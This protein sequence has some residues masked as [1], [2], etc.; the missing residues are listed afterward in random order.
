MRC[1]LIAVGSR[2]DIQP[3]IALALGLKRAGWAVRFA[4]HADFAATALMHGLEFVRISGSSNQ[5]YNGPASIA[6][7]DHIRTGGRDLKRFFDSYLSVFYRRHLH[8]VEAACADADLI[9]CWPW[10]RLAPTL[11]QWRGVPV[12]V[13][14]VNPVIHLPTCTYPNPFQYPRRR[15]LGVVRNRLSWRAGEAIAGIGQ[16]ELDTWRV[17]RLGL[18]PLPWREDLKRLRRMPHLFGV[19]P[20]VM[21]KPWDWAPWIQ[22]TGYWFLD[23]R[24]AYEPAPDLAAFLAAG[25]PPV[26]IGF[27]SQVGRD[28]RGLQRIIAEGVAASGR[29][30]LLI[31]GYGRTTGMALPTNLHAVQTVPYDWLLPRLGAM[32]H[33]GGAGS[34]AAALRWGLPNAAIPFGYEQGFW[35]H[36]IARLGVGPAPVFAED[37]TA[38][39]LAALIRCL[40][41][42]PHY[43]RCAA[44]LAAPLA[45]EDGVARAVALIERRV[46][47]ATG[48]RPAVLGRVAAAGGTE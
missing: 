3:L 34:V 19:S 35:G 6:L 23:E 31:A 5:F 32:I 24:A 29:R 38:E 4:S 8:D 42:D 33:H 43:R 16:L 9:L 14:S 40:A 36:R 25:P 22:V 45:D 44:A 1:V 30:A 13:L 28:A 21:P 41:D 7:R 46:W 17:E 20:L 12:L 10:T 39:R 27:S 37:L 18:S 26:A 47:K 15:T 2:G 48:R 11:A